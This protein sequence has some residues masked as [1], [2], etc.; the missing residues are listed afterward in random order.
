MNIVIG[1]ALTLIIA[2]YGFFSLTGYPLIWCWMLQAAKP[3]AYY[4]TIANLTMAVGIIGAGVWNGPLG[5]I[6]MALLMFGFNLVPTVLE[7]LMGFGYRCG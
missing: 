6:K 4:S 5:A 3:L 2:N 1:W 7:A